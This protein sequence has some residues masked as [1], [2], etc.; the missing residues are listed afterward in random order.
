M[1]IV[2]PGQQAEERQN[3]HFYEYYKRTLKSQSLKS[4]TIP[5]SCILFSSNQS[6]KQAAFNLA[7]I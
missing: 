1:N 4:N 2:L 7:K 5:Q 6:R 3:S